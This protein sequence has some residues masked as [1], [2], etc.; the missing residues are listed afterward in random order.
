MER[1]ARELLR[2]F[3]SEVRVFLLLQHHLGQVFLLHLV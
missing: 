3:A 2:H 1:P